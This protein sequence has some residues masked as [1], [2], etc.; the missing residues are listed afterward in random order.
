MVE[1]QGLSKTFDNDVVRDFGRVAGFNNCPEIIS[2]FL[3]VQQKLKKKII[4]IMRCNLVLHYICSV[5]KRRI[6]ICLSQLGK[7]H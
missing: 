4:Y 6:V 3:L 7:K 5:T 1:D 2:L